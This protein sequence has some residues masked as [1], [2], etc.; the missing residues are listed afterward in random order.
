MISEKSM[1]GNLT[2][3]LNEVKLLCN[4]DVLF[5]DCRLKVFEWYTGADMPTTFKED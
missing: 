2:K 3:L 1:K 4:T 5:D